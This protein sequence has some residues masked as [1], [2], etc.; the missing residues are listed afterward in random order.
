[1]RHIRITE[2]HDYD[3]VGEIVDSPEQFQSSAGVN[4]FQILSSSVS[5]ASIPQV[6]SG[7]TYLFESTRLEDPCRM[8]DASKPAIRCPICKKEV[9][10]DDPSCPFCSD[11]CRI[12]D[13]GNW[14]SEKY[15]IPAP[16]SRLTNSGSKVMTSCVAGRATGERTGRGSRRPTKEKLGGLSRYARVRCARVPEKR[17]GRG[18]RHQTERETR[19]T[20]PRRASP[21]VRE[22]LRSAQAAGRGVKQ[23]R[24]S[25]DLAAT[26]ESVV[27]EFLRSAQ[28]AG[29]GIKQKRTLGG[30]GRDARVRCARV[31][32]SAQA[33]GRGTKQ[34]RNSADLAATR[35]SVVREFLRSAQAAGRGTKQKRNSADL[36]ATRESVVREFLKRSAQA[37]GRGAKRKRNSADLAATRESV[38]RE[39]LEKR[40][41][42]GSRR[43]TKE[44][45]GGL[46]RDARVRCARVPQKMSG[47]QGHPL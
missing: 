43:Q 25:A 9:A 41:G 23:K 16:R 27:R 3:L 21:V 44:K 7:R 15:V 32:R 39:F 19:R 47:Q 38:V 10:W 1:M 20:W 4:P 35:E 2:A 8:P 26:G 5:H 46:G 37:A 42:R 12:I 17:T 6:A 11:R 45:L 30:L 29:R 33:A 28:A 34:K 31:P 40:T 22:F 14:A 18:S 36:A 13:L 24:N